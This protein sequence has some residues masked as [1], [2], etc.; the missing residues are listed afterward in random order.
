MSLSPI[1]PKKN[2][3]IFLGGFKQK[4]IFW[5]TESAFVCGCE[6]GGA[7]WGGAVALWSLKS[8]FPLSH[9]FGSW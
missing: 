9:H 3:K 1:E 5:Y 7:R 2:S 6:G 4:K 8:K